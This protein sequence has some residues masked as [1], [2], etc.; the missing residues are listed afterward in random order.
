[1]AVDMSIPNSIIAAYLQ[2]LRLRQEREE[3]VGAMQF[4]MEDLQRRREEF[5]QGLE[6]RNKELDLRSKLNE[7]L[8]KSRMASE[9][10]TKARR[11]LATAQL[12]NKGILVGQPTEDP[13]VD[14]YMGSLLGEGFA[15][16][17]APSATKKARDEAERLQRVAV[18][19]GQKA[20][21]VAG[22]T[23]QYK[24]DLEKLR[25]Q[26]GGERDL[27]KL[28]VQLQNRLKEL[29]VKHGYDLELEKERQKGREAVAMIKR[30]KEETAGVTNWEGWIE[31]LKSGDTTVETLGKADVKTRTG[32]LSLANE[33]GVKPLSN[34]DNQTLVALGGVTRLY[35]MAQE[36]N[37]IIQK[38]GPLAV[39]D[40]DYLAKAE[41]FDAL[42][43]KFRGMIGESGAF[44]DRDLD[45]IVKLRPTTATTRPYDLNNSKM[46]EFEKEMKTFNDLHLRRFG[47]EQKLMII[48]KFKL[49]PDPDLEAAK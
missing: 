36:M 10:E 33:L 38:K 1:M 12:V 41:S 37:A 21:A 26:L 35:Q 20:G 17:K 15:D 11:A 6:I 40:T 44:T 47:P 28:E 31:G 27:D 14:I 9:A 30:K 8:I 39:T 4:R 13:D 29:D 19:A 34:K 24:I 43:S 7:S 49:L 22:A 3:A 42:A 16:F 48:D 18:G 2:G 23:Q 32:V 25:A 46:K 5:E 45:R